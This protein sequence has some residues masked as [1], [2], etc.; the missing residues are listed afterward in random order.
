[1]RLFL[2]SGLQFARIDGAAN[3]LRWEY[4]LESFPTIMYLPAWRKSESR[5]FPPNLPLTLA[6][7]LRFVLANASAAVRRAFFLGQCDAAC[8]ATTAWAAGRQAALVRRLQRR[9]ARPPLFARYVAELARLRRVWR[10]VARTARG[11]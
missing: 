9:M 8:R 11:S 1:M 5:V 2:N 6:Y 10:D 4:S 7:L 3:D